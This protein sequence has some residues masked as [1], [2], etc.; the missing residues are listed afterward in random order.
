MNVSNSIQLAVVVPMRDE[1]E[2]VLPLLAEIDAALAAL[3]P[4]EII[5]VND[6]SRD[7][8]GDQLR[9]AM[10]HNPRLRVVEH[11]ISCGQSMAVRSGIKAAQAPW[12]ITLDGDG[13]NDP[14]DIP[15]LW[16][17]R[18]E[19]GDAAALT[20][21]IGHRT[22]RQD[23]VI[24]K[25]SSRLAFRFRHWLLGDDTPDTGC[26]IKLFARALYF[27][28]PY[29]DHMHRFISTLVLRQRG[30]VYSLPVN[31]RPRVRGASKYGTLD[32]LAVG[33]VDILGVMWLCQRA[34]FPNHNQQLV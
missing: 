31:H 30:R 9:L 19:L 34:R 2:N 12:I 14:A 4:A 29:F 8:T 16:R 24:K 23:S 33:I 5:V 22:K 32:R 10:I 15:N 11:D 27:E 20:L 18:Q 6:G 17:V 26:G 1:A 25:I 3:P 13:Q 28:L 21:V 7:S